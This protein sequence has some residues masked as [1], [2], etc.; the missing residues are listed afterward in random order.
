M[1]E[2]YEGYTEDIGRDMAYF[3]YCHFNPV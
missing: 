2:P 1:K 3:M